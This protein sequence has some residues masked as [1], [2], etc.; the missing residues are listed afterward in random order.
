[1]IGDRPQKVWNYYDHFGRRTNNDLEDFDKHA[2]GII[3]SNN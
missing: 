3:Y 2:N 1:M